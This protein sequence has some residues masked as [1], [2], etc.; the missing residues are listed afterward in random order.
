MTYG[1]DFGMGYFIGV[2][3]VFLFF[4]LPRQSILI[5]HLDR[6][7]LNGQGAQSICCLCYLET[8]KE[9]DFGDSVRNRVIS[10]YY[11]HS[12]RWDLAS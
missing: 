9:N 4:F 11:R 7:C 2:F 1:P 10:S 3:F 6:N 8:V 5:L 12:G